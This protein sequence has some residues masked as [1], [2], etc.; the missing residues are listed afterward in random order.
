M[1][2]GSNQE[3]RVRGTDAESKAIEPWEK[4]DVPLKLIDIYYD[5]L[6]PNA[7]AGDLCAAY[8]DACNDFELNEAC[9]SYYTADVSIV[10]GSRTYEPS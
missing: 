8:P 4:Q 10:V 6:Q 1:R 7:V 5:I 3:Q 2:F 9:M